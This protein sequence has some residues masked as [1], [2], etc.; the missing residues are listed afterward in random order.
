MN[1]ENYLML[2][3]M[4]HFAFCRRQW[5]L[6]HLEEQWA[7]NERTIDGK[8]MHKTAHDE[9]RTEK[10][11]DKIITRGMRIVSHQLGLSGICDVVE[12]NRSEKGIHLYGWPDLWLPYPVEYKKGEPKEHDADILQLTAQAI[13]LEE[14]LSCSIPEGSLYYGEIRRR[15]KVVFSEELRRRVCDMASEMHQLYQKGR[16]PKAKRSKSCNA[17]SLKDICLPRLE[18]TMNVRDYM[19][20]HMQ[21]DIS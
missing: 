16:T 13:C 11:G 6:I 17:C 2:S 10:R 15:Q 5:A 1:E 9:N 4:Q 19:I 7:E 14:M 8:I 21:G 3:G 12:F 20:R 18:K